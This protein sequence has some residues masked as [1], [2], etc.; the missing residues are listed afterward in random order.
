MSL[1]YGHHVKDNWLLQTQ[2]PNENLC[3]EH[4]RLPH[5]PSF[6]GSQLL[7]FD[8]YFTRK[9]SVDSGKFSGIMPKTL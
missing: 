6:V 5:I 2:C 7:N 4:K 1:A 8:P 3:K 9:K